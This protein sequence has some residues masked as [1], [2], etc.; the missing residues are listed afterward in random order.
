[1]TD[2]G[3]VLAV[4]VGG[5][6][7]KAGWV[8]R[9]GTLLRHWRVPTP[10][11]ETG[12]AVADAV[13]DL[14][15]A[16]EQSGAS[17][18][19][20]G[21]VVPG[22][23]DDREGVVVEAVNLG[24]RD[25]PLRAMLAD[26]ILESGRCLP[27]AFS[28]DIRAGALA[29]AEAAGPELTGLVAFIAVGTGVAAAYTQGGEPLVSA[30]LSGEIGQLSLRPGVRLEQVAS[31]A[32]IAQRLEVRGAREAAELVCAGDTRARLV[33]DD[34]VNALVEAIAWM[35]AI[36]GVEAVVIGGGLAESGDLLLTPLASKLGSRCGELGAPRVGRAHHGDTAALHGAAILALRA[37]SRAGAMVGNSSPRFRA[38]ENKDAS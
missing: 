1:M 28:Q 2:T 26:R 33:W 32:A 6:S 16:D 21:V 36:I 19:G 37:A 24:W 3:R 11:D 9:D 29:E 13:V 30:P 4:D 12:E 27:L 14:L 20:I 8:A 22:I 15:T 38:P 23:V 7:I 31:A 5:T 25:L 34:A 18:V 35:R 10:R 17:A